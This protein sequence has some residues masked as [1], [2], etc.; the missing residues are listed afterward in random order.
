MASSTVPPFPSADNYLSS[1]RESARKARE[2]SGITV[3][4]EA[5]RALL[6][7]SAFQDTF[8]TL[9]TAHGLTLPLNFPSPL[10]E[11]NL[12]SLLSLINFGSGY[13]IPLHEATGRGAWDSIRCIIL[14]L[15]ISSAA[16]D[17]SDNLSARAIKE[18]SIARVAEMMNVSLHIERP[19]ES[20]PGVT[21][22]ELGG[23]LYELVKL[24]T[25]VLNETGGILVDQGYPDLGS[26]VLESLKESKRL[27]KENEVDVDFVLDKLVRAIPAFRDMAMVNGQPT[28]VFKKA[29]FL[30]HGIT[31]R[32]GRDKAAGTAIPYPSTSH[33][34]VFSDNVIPSMLVHLRILDLSTAT[35]PSLRDA[36]KSSLALSD[37]DSLLSLSPDKE[38]TPEERK[39]IK[40]RARTHAPKQGPVLAS[41]DAFVLRAAAIDA[42]EDI[43]R[44]AATENDLPE[45]IKQMVLPELDAWLWAG[46][47]DRSDYRELVRFVERNTV[48]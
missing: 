25:D 41:E 38:F 27:S 12:L 20:I 9:S 33:L 15:F 18:I 39:L 1:I 44:I 47:K 11:L 21:V 40:D 2:S 37:I 10:S 35:S 32:F 30:L 42:C 29:L 5:I 7:S 17:G 31:Q 45:N 14:S 8:Q 46:A 34:P 43:I 28:Y 6:H 3:S 26:F 22:G 19:H 23:P 16:E 48:F 36:F 13:R 24:V 4:H